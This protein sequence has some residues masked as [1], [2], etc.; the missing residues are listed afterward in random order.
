[1]FRASVVTAILHQGESAEQFN[2]AN[3]KERNFAAQIL[4]LLS[5]C[6]FNS[7]FAQ[8]LIELLKLING[9]DDF[10][11]DEKFEVLDEIDEH[12]S[13]DNDYCEQLAKSTSDVL[14]NT[15]TFHSTPFPIEEVERA[16]KYYRKTEKGF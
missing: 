16:L 12:N 6:S 4:Q 2:D 9:S 13:D 5:R 14:P 7:D 1:M 15:W 10:E 8:R 3:D 11:F